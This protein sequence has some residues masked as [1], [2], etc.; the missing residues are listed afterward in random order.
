MI[1]KPRRIRIFNHALY[2]YRGSTTNNDLTKIHKKHLKEKGHS[3]RTMKE[4][5]T[6]YI[7]SKN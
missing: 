1:K 2:F 5:K 4:G 3:V 7:Y 6:T